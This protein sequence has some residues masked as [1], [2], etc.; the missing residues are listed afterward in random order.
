MAQNQIQPGVTDFRAGRVRAVLNWEGAIRYLGIGPERF[1]ELRAAGAVPYLRVPRCRVYGLVRVVD[2]DRYLAA[3]TDLRWGPQERLG[4]RRELGTYQAAYYLHL[5]EHQ[6]RRLARL[7]E[8]PHEGGGQGIAY[9]FQ[10]A[11]LDACLEEWV[12]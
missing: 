11:E 5:S 12:K 7:E 2:L 10:V 9:R 1:R 6:V 4:G 3:E 8:L